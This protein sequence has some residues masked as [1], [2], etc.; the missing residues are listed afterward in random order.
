M[1]AYVAKGLSVGQ[2]RASP[3]LKAGMACSS[4]ASIFFQR[5]MSLKLYLVVVTESSSWRLA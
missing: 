5:V 4:F 3:R 1:L 2:L